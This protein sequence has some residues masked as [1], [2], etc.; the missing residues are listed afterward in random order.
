MISHVYKKA[1]FHSFQ[2]F[3]CVTK[4]ID[5]CIYRVVSGH[6]TGVGWMVFFSIFPHFLIFLAGRHYSIDW[7]ISCLCSLIPFF[8]PLLLLLTMSETGSSA[9]IHYVLLSRATAFVWIIWIISCQTFSLLP[10]FPLWNRSKMVVKWVALFRIT[11]I[12]ALESYIEHL[13]G[14]SLEWISR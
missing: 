9:V 13:S 12:L 8:T 7:R 3:M 2:I 14:T 6:D 10:L 4:W 1:G 11:L 5:L